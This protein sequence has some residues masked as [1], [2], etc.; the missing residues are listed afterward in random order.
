[1]GG[2][3]AKAQHGPEGPGEG[4]REAGSYRERVREAGSCR[5]HWGHEMAPCVGTEEQEEVCFGFT[6]DSKL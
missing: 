2:V 5:Q 1:M 4:G 6:D 3:E